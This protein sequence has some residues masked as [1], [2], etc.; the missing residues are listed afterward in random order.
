MNFPAVFKHMIGCFEELFEILLFSP[1]ALLLMCV[2]VNSS[3]KL[4]K[5]LIFVVVSLF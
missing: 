2:Y 3:M 4:I 1:F 5:D